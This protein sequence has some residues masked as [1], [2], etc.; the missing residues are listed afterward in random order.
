MKPTQY[1][2]ALTAILL[3]SLT[4]LPCDAQKILYFDGAGNPVKEKKA[5]LLQER[6]KIND[7]LWDFS[8]YRIKK[9]RL[10]SMQFR[11]EQ[12]LVPN[13]RFLHYDPFGNCD[14]IG[15][16]ANGEKEGYWETYTPKGRIIIRREYH[17]DSLVNEE[18]SN[19]IKSDS[20]SMHDLLYGGR[21]IVETESEFPGG[22]KAWLN[23]LRRKIQYAEEEIE[24]DVPGTPVIFFTI[25][26]D[27]H[28]DAQHTY[29]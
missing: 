2:F 16:Y 27:G 25:L 8:T 21:K 14:T 22:T 20:K 5:L 19:E 28:L 18:D 3:G 1:L 4:A 23:F 12:G 13:G 6:V 29:V 10:F 15:H 9:P 7:T 17:K 11:D 26:A 24:V